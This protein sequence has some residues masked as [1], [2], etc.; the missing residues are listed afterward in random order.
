MRRGIAAAGAR[1]EEEHRDRRNTR[2]TRRCPPKRVAQTCD[3]L[4]DVRTPLINCLAPR[5]G[6]R[7]QP[8]I[9]RFPRVSM[10]GT[11]D[12]QTPIG[13][14]RHSPLTP[15]TSAAKHASSSGRN[16]L[17]SCATKKKKRRPAYSDRLV[18]QETCTSPT[19]LRANLVFAL[20][21]LPHA[22]LVFARA[23]DRVLTR[24]CLLV[25]T[26]AGRNARQYYPARMKGKPIERWGR[27]ASGL[28]CQQ[29][30]IT[31]LPV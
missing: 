25:E 1:D 16:L 17:S 6:R 23:V 30:K 7:R 29:P 24:L 22:S 18:P 8:P 21:P 3:L 9:R 12:T 15:T 11:H 14:R 4:T 20:K 19:D 2:R 28:R 5:S 13:A 27:K 10:G 31:G 26:V